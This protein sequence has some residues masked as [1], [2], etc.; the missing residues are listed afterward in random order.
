MKKIIFVFI[1]ALAITACEKS[2]KVQTVSW[3]KEHNKERM[4]ML[5]KCGDNPGE[6]MDTPN[7]NNAENARSDLKLEELRAKMAKRR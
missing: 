3:Y 2:E 1:T 4:E 5:E 7:C 6:L